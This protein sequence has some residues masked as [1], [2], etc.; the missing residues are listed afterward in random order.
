MDK[1]PEKFKMV[2]K[3]I[4]KPAMTGAERIQKMR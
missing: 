2:T 3:K 1:H 4:K